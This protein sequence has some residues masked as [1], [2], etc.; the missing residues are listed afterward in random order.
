VIV[1]VD[2]TIDAAAE[3]GS[4][5]GTKPR[6]LLDPFVD[7]VVGDAAEDGGVSLG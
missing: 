5:N 7:E 3:S 6:P 2:P 1:V 4:W